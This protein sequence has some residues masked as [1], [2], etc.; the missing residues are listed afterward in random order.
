MICP[1]LGANP[2]G[3]DD[4]DAVVRQRH[5]RR[6]HEG[7]HQGGQIIGDWPRFGVL[8]DE[9]D[10]F[11][12]DDVGEVVHHF[13]ICASVFRATAQACMIGSFVA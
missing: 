7:S 10:D 5:R 8:L 13:R 3:D 4:D 2:R 9:A 11:V 12:D 1:P 6:R